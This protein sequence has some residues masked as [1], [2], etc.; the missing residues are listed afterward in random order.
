M[1]IYK[2]TELESCL[3]DLAAATRSKKRYG[4]YSVE[5]ADTFRKIKKRYKLVRAAGGVVFNQKG[6]LLVIKRLGKWDLP[7][8]KLEKGES[9]R[10]GALREVYEECGIPFLAIVK[11][12]SDT[13]HIYSTKT[14]MCLKHTV[15]YQMISW[16]S[17]KP[18]PQE[19]EQITEACWVD[20]AELPTLMRNT[21]P[22]LLLIF[23][24]IINR[25]PP[26]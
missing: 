17:V 6:Q 5:P 4:I 25:N 22:S 1:V 15:W 14:E 8:G 26:V 7:K 21:Y 16:K 23:N 13:Y 20:I 12:D 18:K 10:I 2:S 24:K 19:K 11:K 9:T 3:N